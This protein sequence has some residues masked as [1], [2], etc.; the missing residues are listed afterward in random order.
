MNE[1]SLADV[2]WRVGQEVGT[3]EWITI[4]QTTV[5]LFADAT[6]D[7]QFIHVDPER[8][9]VE[10]PFGGTI[11]HGFLT[12]SLLSVMNF[13]GMPKIREQTMG[14]NYGFDHVR[15]MSPVKTGSRVR[16]RFVLSDCRFRGASMLVTTYEV[17]VEIENESRPALTA[18]WITVVQFDPKDRPKNA[19]H[20]ITS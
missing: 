15:F 11:A 1:I 14:L 17:T 6:H 10:S 12:L 5:N 9:A 20:A 19:S 8:A 7:H 2:S 16:G 4:D 3:S 18:N 13:S